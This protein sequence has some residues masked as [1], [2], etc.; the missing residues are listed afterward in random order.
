MLTWA[1]PPR[2]DGP[3]KFGLGPL[4]DMFLNALLE[5]QRRA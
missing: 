1:S 5:R 2:R 3:I 4:K